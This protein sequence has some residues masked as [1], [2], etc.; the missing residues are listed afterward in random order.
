MPTHTKFLL[1]PEH[2]HHRNDGYGN[3]DVKYPYVRYPKQ[4]DKP[5]M[6]PSATVCTSR[7]LL[8]LHLLHTMML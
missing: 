7:P 4:P 1:S 6:H 3:E 2:Q 8:L 5:K